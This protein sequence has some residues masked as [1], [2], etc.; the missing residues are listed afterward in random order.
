[1]SKKIP[2]G[3]HELDDKDIQ[4]VPQV[5]ELLWQRNPGDQ[6]RFDVYRNGEHQLIDVVL[7][8]VEP[9]LI[10]TN[11][12]YADEVLRNLSSDLRPYV[13]LTVAGCKMATVNSR[14][15]TLFN[16][17]PNVCADFIYIDG[18]GQDDP[19]GDIDGISTRHP[20]RLPMVADII[21]LEH[22][23][24]PGTVIVMDGRTANARFMK[25]NFQLEWHYKYYVDFDQHVF[26]NVSEPLGVYNKRELDFKGVKGV[27]L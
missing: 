9:K 6:I 7:G 24:L 19:T 5:I 22:F 15:C 20:D 26:I 3:L 10:E 11:Q 13:H 4:V 2:Y 21:R 17:F 14:I 27:S 25:E 8:T 18:P 16:D 12:F 23:L 1:M